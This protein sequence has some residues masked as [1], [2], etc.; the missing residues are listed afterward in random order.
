MR[1]V[2]VEECGGS[3]MLQVCGVWRKRKRRV[4]VAIVMEI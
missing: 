3:E 1:W 4:S 2:L